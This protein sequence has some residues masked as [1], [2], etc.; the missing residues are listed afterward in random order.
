MTF[1]FHKGTIRTMG[2][3]AGSQVFGWGFQFHKGTIRTRLFKMCT[4]RY[5]NIS[6]P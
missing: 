2:E 4:L 5:R 6:I 1:Q 3:G